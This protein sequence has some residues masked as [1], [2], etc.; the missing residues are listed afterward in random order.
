MAGLGAMKRPTL[1]SSLR[2]QVHRSIQAWCSSGLIGAAVAMAIAT[3]RA[4]RAQGWQQAPAVPT[5]MR[6]TLATI[7]KDSKLFQ[8]Y[9]LYRENRDGLQKSAERISL[10]EAI[11]RGL[12][13]SPILAATEIGRAHV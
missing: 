6:N 5:D 10:A 7:S 12:A 13:T 4:V 1:Q 2:S 8:I 9:Q 11:Q 3:P